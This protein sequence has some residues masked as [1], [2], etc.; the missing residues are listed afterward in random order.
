MV[1]EQHYQRLEDLYSPSDLVTGNVAVGYGRA[2]LHGR[3]GSTAPDDGVV[4]RMPHQTLLNDAAT[5]AA[6]SLEKEKKVTAEQ[7]DASVLDPDYD[8]P[9][10]AQAQIVL[11]EPPAMV[12]EAVL[13]TP[14]EEVVATARG[15]FRPSGVD[16]PEEP[17]ESEAD[18]DATLPPAS[19]MPV[20]Q[21][22]HGMLCLN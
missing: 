5:L 17:P 2:V 16:L 10:V 9:V 14:N 13:Q 8:G 12:V 1:S 22:E 21:T 3:L 18:T 19:F 6:G 11:T 4:S 7:F 20:F 15:V